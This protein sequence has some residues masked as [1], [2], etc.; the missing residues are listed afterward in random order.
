MFC[1]FGVKYPKEEFL[2]SVIILFLNFFGNF[3]LFSIVSVPIH[4]PK[5]SVFHLQSSESYQFIVIM[6]LTFAVIR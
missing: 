3:I 1:D 4:I 5:S 6:S 2:S